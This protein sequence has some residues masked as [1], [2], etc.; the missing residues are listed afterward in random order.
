MLVLTD[1]WAG[2]L[3]V[4]VSRWNMD[5]M[6]C[7]KPDQYAS[8]YII[9]HRT[10][11]SLADTESSRQPLMFRDTAP[12][13]RQH[14]GLLLIGACRHQRQDKIPPN[15]ERKQK[16]GSRERKE[17][18]HTTLRLTHSSLEPWGPTQ[19]M[20][21]WGRYSF[22]G[23]SQIQIHSSD[24]SWWSVTHLYSCPADIWH[25]TWRSQACVWPLSQR[26]YNGKP[27]H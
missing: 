24:R 11:S 9:I 13:K 26:S 1:C 6:L 21:H 3:N 19:T 8:D 12:F 22:P 20:M 16:T 14:W 18:E 2:K 23:F 4:N 7:R 17:N 27:I 25:C 5:I 15:V 10:K